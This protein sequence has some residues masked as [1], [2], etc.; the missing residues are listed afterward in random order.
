MSPPA[1]LNGVTVA[2]PKK[3][4]SLFPAQDIGVGVDSGSWNIGRAFTGNTR[5]E[6]S[7][8][9]AVTKRLDTGG[10]AKT[11]SGKTGGAST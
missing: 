5:E 9:Y 8:W 4:Q 11:G 2:F 1:D 10:P 7:V 6:G 3:K